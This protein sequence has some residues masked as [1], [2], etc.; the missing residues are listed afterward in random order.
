VPT[1]LRLKTMLVD[2]R[3]KKL[4][5]FFANEHHVIN[6]DEDIFIMRNAFMHPHIGVCLAWYKAQEM[7][8]IGK[9]I[10]STYTGG[11]E[12]IEGTHNG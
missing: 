12:A 2:K 3:M 1:P 4:L 11:T 6:I 8:D 9:A 7:H 5:R 10:M